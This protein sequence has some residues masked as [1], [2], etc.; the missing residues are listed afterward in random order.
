MLLTSS[1]N[2][3]IFSP[4]ERLATRPQERFFCRR[5]WWI[6]GSGEVCVQPLPTISSHTCLNCRLQCALYQINALHHCN[7][8]WTPFRTRSVWILARNYSCQYWGSWRIEFEAY[9]LFCSSVVQI[10]GITTRF[11]DHYWFAEICCCRVLSIG[12]LDEGL[13]WR[14][15]PNENTNEVQVEMGQTH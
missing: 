15:S 1:S 10:N 3:K 14:V 6:S 9:N 12:T 2:N 8:K 11:T 7:D 13:L 4:W 5:L